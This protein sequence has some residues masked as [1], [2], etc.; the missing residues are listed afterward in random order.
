MA[1]LNLLVTLDV[2]LSEGSVAG[3]ARR[4]RL[5][6]S[7]MSRA[8]ARLREV[9]GDPLLVRAGRGLVPTP[10]AIELRAQVGPLVETARAVLRPAEALDLAR[11]VRPFTLRSSEG[12]AETFG[13]RLLALVAEQ[14]PGV[15]LQFLTKP[16]K[17]SAPLREGEADLETG[18][19]DAA[20]APE[21]R[22]VP[23][24][25]DRW[26][27]VVRGDHPLALAPVTA[28]LFAAAAHVQVLRRGL[29]SNEIDE[30]ARLAGLERR[31]VTVVSGFSTAL[32]LARRTDLVA[33]V[34]ERH[35][36]GLRQGLCSFDL[37]FKVPSFTVSMLWHPRMD[38]DQAHRWLRSQVR[39]ACAGPDRSDG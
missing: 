5:S 11:L 37:P 39:A 32:A 3:A 28:D 9:T 15:T 4:L 35:T 10:R 22:A 17:D 23:L 6:P 7:A 38:G 1:D 24:F 14:A 20:T 36:D 8:L 13:P 26:V 12:F 27:G 19:I 31:V 33:V 21:L 30:A 34:P 29:H 2:L 18:V 25:R 16:D